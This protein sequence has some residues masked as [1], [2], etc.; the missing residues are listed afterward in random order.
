MKNT[1]L[2][3]GTFAL[4]GVVVSLSWADKLDYGTNLDGIVAGQPARAADVRGAFDAV[5]AA[6]DG[7]PSDMVKVGPVC[8]DKYEAYVTTDAAGTTA[9]VISDCSFT[10]N[11]CSVANSNP[12]VTPSP[13]YAH[14][15]AGVTPSVGFTWF[16]AAQACAN[17]GK[18]LP[19]NAEWQMAAAGTTDD[20][21]ACNVGD[22]M[23]ALDPTGSNTSCVSNYGAFDM[24]GNANEYVADWVQSANINAQVTITQNSTGANYGNDTTFAGVAMNQGNG[25]GMPSAIIRGGSTVT[26][27]NAAGV[28][29][30]STIGAP[31]L[32]NDPVTGFRCAY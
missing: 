31:T 26:A 16:Q 4:L 21:V 14:S 12:A 5:K 3:L 9:A 18:R 6:I 7:C 30:M 11:D 28:F 22:A 23:A 32:Y 25:A 2:T 17:V 1:I 20:G 13:I 29:F 27:A 15:R 10:G 19:T 8:I 24:V